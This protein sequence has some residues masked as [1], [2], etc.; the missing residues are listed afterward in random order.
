MFGA[1]LLDGLDWR[2]VEKKLREK[3]HNQGEMELAQ[4]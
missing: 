4:N 3:K 2:K 1:E